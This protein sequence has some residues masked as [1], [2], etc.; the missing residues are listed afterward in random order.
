VI[1]GDRFTHKIVF[2]FQANMEKLSDFRTKVN[3]L[4]VV[5]D[6]GS[7]CEELPT[8]G[9]LCDGSKDIKNSIVKA[10]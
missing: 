6:P 10:N 3:H 5:T 8:A 7:L 2:S 4:R 1:V 9:T